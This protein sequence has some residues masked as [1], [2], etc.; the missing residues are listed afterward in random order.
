MVTCS[1]MT[2][3]GSNFFK[4]SIFCDY[5]VKFHQCLTVVL[6]QDRPAFVAFLPG[7]GIFGR[8]AKYVQ[9]DASGRPGDTY[10]G[11]AGCL[12]AR[13]EVLRF[14]ADPKTRVDG[15]RGCFSLKRVKNNSICRREFRRTRFGPCL[16]YYMNWS[17]VLYKSRE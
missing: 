9:P 16:T 2:T 6:S 13:W 7:D 11:R 1:V 10:R 8:L 15:P 3:I 17:D 12:I 4:D 5:C 14:S